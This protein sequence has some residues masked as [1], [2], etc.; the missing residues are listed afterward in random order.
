MDR[1]RGGLGGALFERSTKAAALG[2]DRAAVGL[3]L[4]LALIPLSFL[5]GTGPWAIASTEAW[6]TDLA[7]VSCGLVH[8]HDMLVTGVCPNYGY[9]HGSTTANG[10][11]LDQAAILLGIILRLGPTAALSACEC[12]MLLVALIGAYGLLRDVGCR[13][14]V[15]CGGALVWMVNPSVLGMASFGSTMWGMALLPTTIAIG[16][17]AL[18]EEG[19]GRRGCRRVLRILLW[20]ATSVW[21]ILLDGYSFVVSMSAVGLLSVS[22][23]MSRRPR[24]RQ[25]VKG[26]VVWGLGAAT[27]YVWYTRVEG[28]MSGSNTGASLDFVRAMGADVVSLV[29]PSDKILWARLLG[30]GIDVSTLWGDGTNLEWNYLGMASILLAVLGA[31]ALRGG[32]ARVAP[33]AVLAV[34]ACVLAL[35]PSVK[36]DAYRGE[37]PA[38]V[39]AGSYL[40]PA[41]DATVQLPWARLFVEMPG[42]SM[43]RA[44]YRWLPLTRLGLVV[45]GAIYVERALAGVRNGSVRARILRAVALVLAAVSVVETLPDV[46]RMWEAHVQAAASHRE[47]AAS[48]YPELDG[49]LADGEV[50]ALASPVSSGNDFLAPELAMSAHVTTYNLAGDKDV[51]TAAR[52]WTPEIKDIVMTKTHLDDSVVKALDSG[53]AGAVVIPMFDLRWGIAYWPNST[54]ASTSTT[55]IDALAQ[56]SRLEV[57]RTATFAVITLAGTGS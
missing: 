2:R 35:G 28:R 53:E 48:V 10:L 18:P 30:R 36:I 34:V 4:L 19:R 38:V 26:V 33:W 13:R 17:A 29:A 8:E 3:L 21:L 51:S 47:R 11:V 55:W 25:A 52:Y 1:D 22:P 46:P 5:Y 6:A 49:L 43:M 56:D 40:M 32:R 27:A 15:S 57:R 41:S 31:I 45:M 12:L 9:P 7:R 42:L 24:V 44:V 20:V 39:T 54:Y 50:V 23:L 16:R 14:W 37:L